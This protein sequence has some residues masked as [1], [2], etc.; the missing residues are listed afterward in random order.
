MA[1]G[2]AQEHGVDMQTTTLDIAS[3]VQIRPLGPDDRQALAAAFSHLSEETR[4]RRFGG[5]AGHLRDRDLD[6]L[7][8]IDHHD[9]Q[10]L[11]AI[12]PDTGA[13]VGV[14]RYVVVPGEPR[15]AEVAV[16]VDDD[17]QRRGI[18]RR[19]MRELGESAR[20]EGVTRLVAYIEADNLPVRR[21]IA[22]AGGV[23][24]EHDAGVYTLSLD[25]PGEERRAA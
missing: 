10:A 7:T 22:R 3:R 2:T 20:A 17:W 9:H 6:R 11:V 25:R 18:G 19:L 4:R 1:A 16:A 12:A 13:I 8:A 5:L 15:A 14:A 23:A 24:Q 21:W